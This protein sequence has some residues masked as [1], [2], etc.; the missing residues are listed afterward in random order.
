MRVSDCMECEHYQRRTWSAAYHP[1]DYHVIGMTHAYGFCRLHDLRCSNVKSC[2]F[3]SNRKKV[4][5]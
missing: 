5:R 4:R 2:S 3:S 1:V